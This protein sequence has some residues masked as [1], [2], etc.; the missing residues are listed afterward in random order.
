M[1][2]GLGVKTPLERRFWPSLALKGQRIYIAWATVLTNKQP[3]NL[4]A[5]QCPRHEHVV[6]F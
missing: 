2:G 6:I 1:F 3:T 5:S 4:K